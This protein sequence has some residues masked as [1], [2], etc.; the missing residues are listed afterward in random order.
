MRANKIVLPTFEE[1]IAVRHGSSTFISSN[2]LLSSCSFTL[3]NSFP[4]KAYKT[5]KVFC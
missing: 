2:G 4:Q 1:F 3:T 5:T